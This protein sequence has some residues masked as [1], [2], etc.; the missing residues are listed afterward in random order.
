L[1]GDNKQKIKKA[2]V[3]KNLSIKTASSLKEAVQLAKKLAVQNDVVILS[4]GA[5]SFDMFNGYDDRG[6]K[7]KNLI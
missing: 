5:A 3:K 7:F 4:P 1:I 6:Q 2:L